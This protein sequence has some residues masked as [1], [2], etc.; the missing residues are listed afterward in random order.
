MDNNWGRPQQPNRN[1][2]S[3]QRN[4]PPGYDYDAEQAAYEAE[5]LE[6]RKQRAHREHDRK[7]REAM[8]RRRRKQR[9]QLI[10]LLLRVLVLIVIICIVVFA[11]KQ[12]KETRAE[13]A[14][15]KAQQE[16]QQNNP[17]NDNDGAAVADNKDDQDNNEDTEGNDTFADADEEL[18]MTSDAYP[19]A[20]KDLY[21]KNEEAREFVLAYPEKKGTADTSTLDEYVNSTEV[22]LLMQWDERWGYY[23]YSDSVIGVAGCGP[24][25]LSMVAIYVNNDPYMTPI[26]IADFAMENGYCVEGSGTEWTLME[27]GAR[28]LGLNVEEL[29]LDE[30]AIARELQAGNPIICNMGP[31]DFTD[32][33][34]YIVLTSWESGT[35]L[36]NDPNSYENYL[37]RWEFDD[38]KDQIKN[39]WVYKK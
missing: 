28:R 18:V 20:L 24:T 39:L 10:A 4:N 16:S 34:H 32:N 6:Y 31:G 5:L 38:I 36:V 3:N 9:K 35:V 17:S 37:K 7:K 30:N 23:E 27:E 8:E 33:G 13:K 2:Y 22:P 14:A 1:R 12:I 15:I 21:Q 11:V 19:Q 25:C 26:E 29:Q